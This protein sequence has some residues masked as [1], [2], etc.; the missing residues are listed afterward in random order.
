[1]HCKFLP[2]YHH[3]H[4][5]KHQQCF[6]VIIR[7]QTSIIQPKVKAEVIRQFEY[8][9]SIKKCMHILQYDKPGDQPAPIDSLGFY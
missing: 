1:M 3:H 8:N 9:R 5:L 2:I 6:T 7:P 4:H